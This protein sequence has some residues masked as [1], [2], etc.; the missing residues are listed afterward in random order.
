VPEAS[1][2]IVITGIGEK[3]LAFAKAAGTVCK[4]QKK[5]MAVDVCERLTENQLI[6]SVRSLLFCN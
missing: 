1:S 4:W 6:V 5:V 3:R 2:Y